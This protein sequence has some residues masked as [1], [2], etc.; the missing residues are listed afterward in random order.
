MSKKEQNIIS[1]KNKK[2]EENFKLAESSN[3]ENLP[4]V[5]MK[6]QAGKSDAD[7]YPK[8]IFKTKRFDLF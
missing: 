3:Q 2:S 6:K 5:K 8:P 4:K 1:G 7:V